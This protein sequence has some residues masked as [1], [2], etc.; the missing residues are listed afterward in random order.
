MNW[1]QKLWFAVAAVVGIVLV[2]TER[3]TALSAA[4]SGANL[5]VC[6]VNSAFVG[7]A[8]VHRVYKENEIK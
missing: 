2:W 5:E 1:V 4:S 8:M 7:I 3:S 6:L